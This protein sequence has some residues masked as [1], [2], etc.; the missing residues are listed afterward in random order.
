[1]KYFTNC[2]TI[3]EV[4]AAFR[5]YAKKL[6]PDCGGDPS[7][8]RC[9]MDEY[10]I[11]YNRYKN[12]H[13]RADGTT[14][15]QETT[16]TSQEY[17]EIIQAVIHMDG[18]IIEIIGSWIWLEGT[19]Y[20]YREQIKAAGFWYSKSKKAWYHNGSTEKSK[21]KGHFSMEQIK[22]RFGVETVETQKQN[23]IA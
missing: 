5:D 20:P 4:K 19:T 9:M 22:D 3:E 18:V 10:N 13:T 23:A 17:A 16:E 15:E 6:H 1:M 11:A 14:Y 2:R 12:I 8:F 7:E 21:K